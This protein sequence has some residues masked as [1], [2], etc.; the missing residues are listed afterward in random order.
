M[1]GE[2]LVY[3]YRCRLR[4]SSPWAFPGLQSQPLEPPFLLLQIPGFL[5]RNQPLVQAL[6]SREENKRHE[7]LELCRAT[8]LCF[9]CPATSCGSVFLFL[10][11]FP[12]VLK[13]PCC[14]W[15]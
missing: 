6:L 2:V 8:S 4:C 14:L 13:V 15:L 10:G 11:L 12:C 3:L 1:D 9:L 5:S 7:P